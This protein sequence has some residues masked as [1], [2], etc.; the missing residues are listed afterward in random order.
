MGAFV[1]QDKPIKLNCRITIPNKAYL[2]AVKQEHKA[3]GISEIVRKILHNAEELYKHGID[4]FDVH[5]VER[6]RDDYNK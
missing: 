1:V 3:E 6:I 5:V 2:E 4:I